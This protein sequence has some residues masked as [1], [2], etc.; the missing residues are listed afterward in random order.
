[1]IPSG[2]AVFQYESMKKLTVC[3]VD[4]ERIIRVTVA[5][6][7]RDS[8]HKVHE[9]SEP[10][11]AL[12]MLRE[13][14]FDVFITDMRMPGMDGLEF[15]RKTK[16]IRPDAQ[17]IVMTGYGSIPNAIEAMKLGAFNYLT[18]PFKMDELLIS[19]ERI[20]E[21]SELKKDI[22]HLTEQISS[23]FDFSAFVGESPQIKE[24]FGL[25]KL[26]AKNET[27]VL[28]SGETGTGKELLTNII[29]YNSN[30]SGKPL[31]KVS[32]A[33][34]S[35]EIF[36]SELFGHEKGAFTGAEKTRAGRFEMANGGTLYLDD[37]D[38]MP[39]E[40]QVKLLRV[41]EENE[42]ERV[43]GNEAIEVDVR[44]ITSTK[45]DLKKLVEEGKFRSD[46][47]YRLNVFPIEIPPL[48]SRVKDVPVLVNHFAEKF[49]NGVSVSIEN[50][51]MQT[52]NDY[53][54]PGNARELKNMMERMS[55]L[56]RDGVIECKHLPFEIRHP[57]PEA[58]P[59]G[60]GEKTLPEMLAHIECSAIKAA[61]EKCGQNQTRAAKLLGIP[62]TTLRTKMEKHSFH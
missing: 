62:L 58:T 6:E 34:L 44:V 7:L 38:D 11:A 47:Y 20:T 61:M 54:F 37:I 51:V 45:V 33:L 41:L 57:G 3:L 40:L 49:S 18:K 43:G 26:V 32:C 29:H 13:M 42:I 46:L 27:N 31:V 21:S 25:V 9:F 23:E 19:L 16:S 5:D 12:A 8:G 52:L 36:E 53:P 14:S 17:F 10:A 59:F 2:N 24:M 39:L 22:R 1:M 50:E 60:L 30:R 56:A 15:I 55:L 48:R 35:K 4:D 28:I